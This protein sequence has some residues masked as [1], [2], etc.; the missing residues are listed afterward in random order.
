M[1]NLEDPAGPEGVALS[2]VLVIIPADTS[3]PAAR[4]FL[5]GERGGDRVVWNQ[6]SNVV[7]VRAKT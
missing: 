4:P 2:T 1:N 3:G 5:S 7:A 6:R